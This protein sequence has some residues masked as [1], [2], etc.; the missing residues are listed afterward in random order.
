M[1]S[2]TFPRAIAI[3]EVLWS[4]PESRSPPN[5]RFEQLACRIA[6]AGVLTGPITI[7]RPCFGYF[8][9]E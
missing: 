2:Q 7:A 6:S 3:A 9:E 8:W 5:E 1:L 4:H